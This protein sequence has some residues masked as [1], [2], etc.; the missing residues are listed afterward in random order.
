[1]GDILRIKSTVKSIYDFII[2][3]YIRFTTHGIYEYIDVGVEKLLGRGSVLWKVTLSAK[4]DCANTIISWKNAINYF[5]VAIAVKFF[6]PKASQ[7]QPS[8]LGRV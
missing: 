2:S 7:I 8:I 4:S 3:S 1:M 6:V 5:N